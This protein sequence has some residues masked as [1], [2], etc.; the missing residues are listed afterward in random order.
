MRRL[1]RRRLSISITLDEYAEGVRTSALENAAAYGY[2]IMIT[3]AFGVVAALEDD[4]SAWAYFLYGVGGAWGFPL[5]I[6]GATKALR[7]HS[8]EAEG[9]EIL[10]V[11]AFLNAISVLAGIGSAAFVAWIAEGLYSWLLAAGAATVVYLAANGLEYAIAEEGD[12]DR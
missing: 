12:F 7:E 5:V 10:M 8:V 3:S 6:V 2:S 4:P 1:P 11:A 9:T